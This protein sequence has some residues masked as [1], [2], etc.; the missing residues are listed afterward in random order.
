MAMFL[1]EE[2]IKEYNENLN[3]RYAD[4]IMNLAY[5]VIGIG[6]INVIILAISKIKF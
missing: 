3:N 6:L 2:H 5:V 1:K 4:I